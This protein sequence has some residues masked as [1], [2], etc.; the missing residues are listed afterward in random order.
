MKTAIKS[1]VKFDFET[2]LKESLL[3]KTFLKESLKEKTFLKEKLTTVPKFETLPLTLSPFS[4]FSD[5]VKNLVQF[6]ILNV[7]LLLYRLLNGQT[8]RRLR[9]GIRNFKISEKP[10]CV[11]VVIVWCVV[12]AKRNTSH[13]PSLLII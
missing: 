1:T 12:V 2:F 9:K 11:R 4:F 7:F 10:K 13:S 3:Q 5:K 6:K 8:R